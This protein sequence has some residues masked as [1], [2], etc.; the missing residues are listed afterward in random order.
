M[1]PSLLY[2]PRSPS[3]LQQGASLSWPRSVG[4]VKKKRNSSRDLHCFLWFVRLRRHE[5]N[6]AEPAD[7]FHRRN[8]SI[9]LA[10]IPS[11]SETSTC[12]YISCLGIVISGPPS[13]SARAAPHT[14]LVPISLLIAC[15]CLSM[16]VLFHASRSSDDIPSS[17][18]FLAVIIRFN[19][20]NP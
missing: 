20:A 14:V 18:V 13:A 2:R 15:R 19:Q 11:I 7:H 6:L 4:Q 1:P 5:C 16:T 9:T 3:E 8:S 10:S 12:G 17:P